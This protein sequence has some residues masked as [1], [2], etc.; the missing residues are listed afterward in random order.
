MTSHSYIIIKGRTM[1]HHTK[2][3]TA[4]ALGS[5]VLLSACASTGQGQ[6][7]HPTAAQ[8]QKSDLYAFPDSMYEGYWAMTSDINGEMPVIGFRDNVSYNYRFKC[9]A[10]GS[11]TQVDREVATLV[12]SNTGMQLKYQD[13]SIMSELRVDQLTPKQA[14][15]LTQMFIEPNLKAAVPDGI[16]FMYVYRPTPTPI[17]K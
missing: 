11:F 3:L 4:F 6:A 2:C 9:N 13:G 10:D 1:S 17:C 12:P 14:L 7:T 5:A 8:H 15:A 16:Q